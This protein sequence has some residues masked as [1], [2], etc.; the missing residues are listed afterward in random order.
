MG[1]LEG[2]KGKNALSKELSGDSCNMSN[3][4]DVILNDIK[5]NSFILIYIT[6]MLTFQD[7]SHVYDLL[8]YFN[9]CIM[10][11]VCFAFVRSKKNAH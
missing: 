10:C 2:G 6:Y 3:L 4:I 9:M 5:L 1:G 7:I 11:V 8:L